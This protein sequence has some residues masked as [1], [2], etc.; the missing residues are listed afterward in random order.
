[1]DSFATIRFPASPLSQ[2]K[3]APAPVIEDKSQRMIGDQEVEELRQR[4]RREVGRELRPSQRQERKPG[5]RRKAGVEDKAANRAEQAIGAT[6]AEKPARSKSVPKA[7]G[8]GT[9]HAK[10]EAE[11]RG[12][13]KA[14]QEVKPRRKQRQATGALCTPEYSTWDRVM[15]RWDRPSFGRSA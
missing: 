13:V 4:P 12:R 1:M 6:P 15:G 11:T 10:E 9:P 5:Q 2:G 7:K 8:S 3:A 14:R